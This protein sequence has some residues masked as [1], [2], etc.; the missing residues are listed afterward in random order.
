MVS[1]DMFMH[2]LFD[3]LEI[4]V[5]NRVHLEVIIKSIFN[6]RSNSRLGFGVNL[7]HCLSQE[8]SAGVS[9]NVSSSLSLP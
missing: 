6:R 5:S 1:P 3:S 4:F 9:K 7:H 2:L 8:M